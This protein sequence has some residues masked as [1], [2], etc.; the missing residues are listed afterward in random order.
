M[1]IEMND[2]GIRLLKAMESSPLGHMSIF[3]LSKQSSDLGIDLEVLDRK[4]VAKL[5]ARLRI[6][7]PFFLGEETKEVM[8]QIYKLGN[9]T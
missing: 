3:V 8:A 6:V 4:D 7:L 1:A 5:A 2:L 9:N